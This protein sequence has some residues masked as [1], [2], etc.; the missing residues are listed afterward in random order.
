MEDLRLEF[1]PKLNRSGRPVNA[2][3]TEYTDGMQWTLQ[4]CKLKTRTM[5]RS[6]CQVHH[7][8]PRSSSLPP[9][10]Q[11]YPLAPK[12]YACIHVIGVYSCHGVHTTF[13]GKSSCG[14]AV[15]SGLCSVTRN[16]TLPSVPRSSGRRNVHQ[17]WT[18]SLTIVRGNL[19]N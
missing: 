2:P 19:Q 8:M 11:W 16:E 14:A 4:G 10:Q 12:L 17:N 7:K 9:C 18:L 1:F 13:G 3:V 6:F 5:R 15:I